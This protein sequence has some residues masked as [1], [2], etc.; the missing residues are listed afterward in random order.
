[1]E[2]KY[3]WLM[4]LHFAAAQAG[5]SAKMPQ[6]GKNSSDFVINAAN[7]ATKASSAAVER[8]YSKMEHRASPAPLD[9]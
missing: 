7:L 4:A 3:N 2:E 5:T 6:G 1:M 9:V 8:I